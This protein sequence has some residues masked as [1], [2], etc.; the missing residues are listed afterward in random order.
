MVLCF[1]LLVVNNWFILADGFMAVFN[2]R[3]VQLFFVAVYV[4][5]VLVC[6]NIVVAFALDSFN[7]AYEENKSKKTQHGEAPG[8]EELG[9][10]GAEGDEARRRPPPN[11]NSATQALARRP[12]RSFATSAREES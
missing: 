9:A 4:F 5:G 11:P 12:D 10:N 6:L 8:D 1:E 2:K 7:A 3:T